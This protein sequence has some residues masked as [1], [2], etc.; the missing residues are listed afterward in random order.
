VRD[1]SFR[2]ASPGKDFRLLSIGYFEGIDSER[3]IARR[4]SDSRAL[5]PEIDAWHAF[6]NDSEIVCATGAPCPT[7][8]MLMLYRRLV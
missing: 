1:H 4:G 8:L 3:G 6:S 7:L 2:S 5:N